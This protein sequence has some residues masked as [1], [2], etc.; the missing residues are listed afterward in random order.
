MIVNYMWYGMY[1]CVVCYTASM[2]FMSKFKLC[3]VAEIYAHCLFLA[4]TQFHAVA[5]SRSRAIV[6]VVVSGV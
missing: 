4:F 6:I 1:A 3:H 2:I 5:L